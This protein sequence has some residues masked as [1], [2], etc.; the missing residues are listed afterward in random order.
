L[1][2]DAGGIV[3]IEFMVQYAV[4]AWSSKRV[5]LSQWTDNVRQLET[6]AALGFISVE[7]AQTLTSAY[8]AYR[9]ATH[10]CALQESAG[11]VS[12]AEWADL[13]HAVRLEWD[14]WFNRIIEE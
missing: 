4:L 11:S 2:Q 1:K 3:D 5:A 14:A 10:E 6:L 9:S 7:T 8:L 13:R 12:A